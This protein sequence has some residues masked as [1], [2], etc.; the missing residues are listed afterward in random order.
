MTA[1]APPDIHDAETLAAARA[2]LDAAADPRQMQRRCSP[3]SPATSSGAAT[4]ASTCSRPR[5][6]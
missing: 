4:S 1:I 6:W 5:R 2:L 3:P